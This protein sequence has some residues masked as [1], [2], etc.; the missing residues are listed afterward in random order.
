MYF[1]SEYV[2]VTTPKTALLLIDIQQAMF[3]PEEICHEPERLRVNAANLLERA[4]AANA[5]V[6]HVQHCESEGPFA[7]G[8]AGWQ[9]NPAV[10][11]RTDEPVLE[12]WACSAFYNTDLDQ[13]LRAQGIGRLVIAGLQTEFCIDTACR[14][15][16]SLNYAVTLAGDTHSTFD[17]ATLSAEK[18]IAHHNRTL[19]GIVQDVIPAQ[20]VAF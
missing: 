11:P 5:P 20:E 16:Q 15:A 19:R 2:A 6:I 13:R 3:G 14:V 4:R 8:S 1:R 9:I 18:I 10:A 17:T 7:P 12:K